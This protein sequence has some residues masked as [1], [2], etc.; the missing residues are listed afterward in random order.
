MPTPKAGLFSNEALAL[1]GGEHSAGKSFSGWEQKRLFHQLPAGNFEECAFPEGFDSRADGR[2]LISADLDGDGDLD[3]VMLNR[4]AP[5][6]QLFRNDGPNGHALELSLAARSGDPE[7]PGARVYVAS[8]G[9]ER[10]FPVLLARGY[11]S[12]V[13]PAVHVGLG[14]AEDAEVRVVWPDG[15]KERFGKV[16]AGARYRLVQGTG[17]ASRLAA[18][19]PG[20]APTAAPLPTAAT[21]VPGATGQLLVP[22][23]ASWCKPC[24]A[25]APLLNRWSKKAGWTVHALAYQPPAEVPA[26]VAKTGMRFPVESVGPE[27]EAALAA[28]GITGLPAALVFGSDGQLVRIIQ[29]SDRLA[30]A[31]AELA[32]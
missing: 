8:E 19:V 6:L 29:G 25:E 26:L 16:R 13:D 18:W 11:V 21:L 24:A 7:A 12:S 2:S 17:T 10:V 22:L 27:R 28:W 23:V 31:L 15:A 3:L 14:T 30:D 4:S 20:P 9:R 1:F 32:R 5:V